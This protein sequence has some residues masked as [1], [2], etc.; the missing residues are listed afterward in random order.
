MA[1]QVTRC[2]PFWHKCHRESSRSGPR[3]T[4]GRGALS[5]SFEDVYQRGGNPDAAGKFYVDT[6]GW[7]TETIDMPPAGTYTLFRHAGAAKGDNVG[8]MLP[9]PPGMPNASSHWVPYFLVTDTDEATRR[10]REF[11]RPSTSARW[12][13][14]M[15][16]ASRSSA[17]PRARC[18]R[19]SRWATDPSLTRRPAGG[20]CGADRRIAR[21]N[22]F[23]LVN[24]IGTPHLDL[25]NPTYT[26]PRW[27]DLRDDDQSGRPPAP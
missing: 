25:R 2:R 4:R 20:S 11:G 8:G 14:P 26:Y 27:R 17:T 5:T 16:A 23:A 1:R 19:S 10:A 13:S 6:F 9:M 12:T 18:S 7:D 22:A 24:P 3:R 21:P 15:S